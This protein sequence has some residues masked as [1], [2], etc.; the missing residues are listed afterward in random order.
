MLHMGRGVPVK[1]I[2]QDKGDLTLADSIK[3]NSRVM[4]IL[5]IEHQVPN[6]KTNGLEQSK[7]S[8]R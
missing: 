4:T 5:Q 8:Y 7:N 2:E 3:F 1:A 6:Y